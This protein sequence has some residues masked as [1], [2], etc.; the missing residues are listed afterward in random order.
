MGW[1]SSDVVK[2][3][4]IINNMILENDSTNRVEVLLLVIAIIKMAEFIHIV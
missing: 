2:T 1:F 3:G 4:N